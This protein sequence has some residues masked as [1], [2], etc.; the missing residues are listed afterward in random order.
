[1]GKQ[2]L[3][4]ARA[5]WQAYELDR[6]A[7]GIWLFTP[8]GSRFRSS[9]GTTD[10][11]CEVEGGGSPGLDSLILVPDATQRWLATWRVPQ[12]DLHISVE[13]CAWIRR[14]PDVVSFVDWELDPFRLRSGLVAVEDLDDLLEVRS[15][16][17]LSADDADSAVVTAAWAERTLR[18]QAAPFDG[19]GD[20]L[21][22]AA[23]RLR[24]PALVAVPHP[25]AV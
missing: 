22:Q 7:E 2:K 17:L 5:S 23:G 10:G 18:R 6:T 9:D 24:L 1:M 12:R 14:D 8:A 19:R 15:S 25:F 11:E 21:L 16:G 3:Q 13:V 20:Q 4:G